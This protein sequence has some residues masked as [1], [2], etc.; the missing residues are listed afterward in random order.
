VKNSEI[1]KNFI[2]SNEAVINRHIN[3]LPSLLHAQIKVLGLLDLDSKL[4]ESVK[5]FYEQNKLSS[6]EKLE[7]DLRAQINK[8]F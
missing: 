6:Q 8:L 3:N 7:D 2:D 4:T 1:L 5:K